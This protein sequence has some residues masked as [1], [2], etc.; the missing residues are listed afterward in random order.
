MDSGPPRSE[1]HFA[2]LIAQKQLLQR[3][4]SEYALKIQKLKEAQALR[5]KGV[6]AEPAP[7]AP[8][9]RSQPPQPSLH[10]LTQDK[11]TLDSEDA[12]DADDHESESAA[13]ATGTRRHSFRQS[14]SSTKPNLEQ[15]GFTPSKDTGAKAAKASGSP[16]PPTEVFAGLDVDTLRRRYEQQVQLGELL[17]HELQN[18]GETV[19]VG[20]PAAQVRSHAHM[21][22]RSLKTSWKSVCVCVR[23]LQRR[24]MPHRRAQN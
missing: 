2:E 17:L 16:L 13:A 9:P 3:L 4:E 6:A 10:D 7:A 14:S 15:L 12:P 18:A 23:W 22:R 21:P 1:R 8:P 20:A 5:N 11:L 19:V 24:W